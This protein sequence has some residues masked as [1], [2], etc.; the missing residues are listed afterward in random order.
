MSTT[1]NQ[2]QKCIYCGNNPTNHTVSFFMQTIMVP[3][4]PIFKFFALI[5]NRYID[6]LAG[7]IFTPYLWVFRILHLWGINTDPEKA[8]TERSKVIWLE[9]R[10]RGIVM[11][12]ITIF[13]KPVEQYRAKI[14]GRWVYFES[15]PI[16]PELNARS[17]AWMDDKWELKNFLRKNNIPVAFGGSVSNEAHALKIFNQGR[18]P[19]ITKPR[20]GSRGRHT[21]TFLTDEKSFLQGFKIA[22]QLSHFVIAEE[23]LFGSVYRGTY[24]GGE[25][26]GILR[27]DPP[28]ITGDGVHTIEE[29]IKI[30]NKNKNQKVKDVIITPLLKEFIGRQNLTVDSI[31]EKDKTIDLSEKIGLSY[32]GYA[33]E[34]ITKTHP[35]IIN[36][37]K[38]AGDALNA[39]VIGFDFIIP[40]ITLDPDTVHWGIIEANSLP[41]INLHHFPMDSEPVNVAS[42][43][44]DL[45]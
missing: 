26:V 28:R 37:I 20:L 42:K 43:V 25:V 14:R 8:F 11:E 9:A 32:G 2:S 6:I 40:D 24:V 17:Y 27:G 33:V 16:P 44:W 7:Y 34:E 35:K 23:Q 3:L 36:Y 13:G 4:S 10:A 38:R 12:Q 19:F 41:F 18:K 1:P 39:P 15:I 30:K 21:S 5:H 29:L 45:W 22:K 31:I